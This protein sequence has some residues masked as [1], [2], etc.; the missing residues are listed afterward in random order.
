MSNFLYL[1][2]GSVCVGVVLIFVFGVSVL[3][4]GAL[5]IAA[6]LAACFGRVFRVQKLFVVSIACAALALGMARADLFVIT[7]AQE[8]LTHY[9]GQAEV[10]GK[11][12]TDPDRRDKTT[13]LVV[14]VDTVEGFAA[15]GMTL[16][17]AGRDTQVAYGDRV[18]I[19]G[20]VSL[21]QVFETDTGHLFDYP[22]YLR[23][24]GISVQMSYAEV[25]VVEQ[26]HWSL[27]SMLFSIKH[28]FE[29]SLGRLLPEPEGAL[30]AG[31]L[32]GE[33]QSI[34]KEVTDAFVASGLVHIVVLSGYNI[35][36]VADAVF[37]VLAPLP[38]G[39]QFGVGGVLMLFFALMAGTGAA[40][41]R[42]LIMALIAL[43]ARYYNRSALALRALA[44]AVVI[45]VFWNP[46]V[47]LYD[48]SF[49]LSVLATFG[50]ITLSP[51]VEGW[52]PKKLAH[53]PLVRSITASTIAV[54]L[55]L[56]P[57]LLYFSGVLSFFALPANMLVLP[58]IPTTMLLG[59]IAGSLGLLSPLFGFVPALCTEMLLSW[60]L[61]I[62]A[63]T[64]SL[65][66]SVTIIPEFS[67]WILCA[68]YVPLTWFAIKKYQQTASPARSS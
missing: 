43:L 11:V 26:A 32:L 46:L 27:L 30:M 48:P 28:S 61:W 35:A 53:I 14:S 49:I 52:L 31:M 41:V 3:W 56:L 18:R 2:T 29:S 40:T 4:A 57:A 7:E 21:P 63:T 65:P 17:L 15:K 13:R 38:R 47:L 67:G 20:K 50:L 42:A 51:W 23:V 58:I 25:E 10:V 36:I 64:A 34:P 37:R 6:A 5:V 45:M 54:Q 66:F 44:V 33:K 59:F 8:T 12:A 39:V 62:A 1:F 19:K 22:N 16:V 68:A 24:Q 9:V 55:F 60:V